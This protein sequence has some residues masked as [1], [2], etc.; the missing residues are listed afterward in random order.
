MRSNCVQTIVVFSPSIMFYRLSFIARTSSIAAADKFVEECLES[1]S[2]ESEVLSLRSIMCR[3]VLIMNTTLPFEEPISFQ[4]LINP[5]NFFIR[6]SFDTSRSSIASF[7]F[8]M[9]LS[10]FMIESRKDRCSS[11]TSSFTFSELER[12]LLN[13]VQS[14]RYLDS[15]SILSSWSY[16]PPTFAWFSRSAR[17][18]LSAPFFESRRKIIM[19]TQFL[20]FPNTFTEVLLTSF[21]YYLLSNY[22]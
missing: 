1:L 5:R 13:A 4:N 2:L 6:S 16:L 15:L 22:L 7:L 10:K 17:F 8:S 14:L 20:N 19:F 21:D 12:R 11:F 3:S 9:K 18:P